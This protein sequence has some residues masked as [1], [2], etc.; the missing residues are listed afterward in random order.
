VLTFKRAV[1]LIRDPYDAIWSEFQRIVTKSHVGGIDKKTFDQSKWQHN[2]ATLSGDYNQMWVQYTTIERTYDKKD[3][4][5]VKYE[6]LKNEKT[7]ISEM[8]KLADFLE[9]LVCMCLHVF[10]C[11]FDYSCLYVCIYAYI[12]MYL[13]VYIFIR[14]Y[15][16][17]Y[18]YI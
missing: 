12:H 6:D 4:L 3:I 13:F 14:I 17:L 18:I 5:Y 15:V 11:M 16:Y 9:I 8:Q 7:R 2:V 1:L 10:V